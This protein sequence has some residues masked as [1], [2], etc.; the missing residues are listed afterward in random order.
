[1]TIDF[2]PVPKLEHIPRPLRDALDSIPDSALD[3][4]AQWLDGTP[5]AISALIDYLGSRMEQR[6][7]GRT[8]GALKAAPDC[9]F[10]VCPHGSVAYTKRLAMAMGRSDIRVIG[11]SF[12]NGPVVEVDPN[13]IV[14]DH[15]LYNS[16]T[17]SRE[18]DTVRWIQSRQTPA[19]G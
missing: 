5:K 18:R 6:G 11:P 7:T 19:K 12:L 2:S 1:M 9:A 3:P 13:R 4:I 14:F 17:T 10:Y 8:T 16:L 15:A